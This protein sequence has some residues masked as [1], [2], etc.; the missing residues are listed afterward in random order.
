MNYL[1]KKFSN[2]ITGFKSWCRTFK[3]L[4]ESDIVKRG[5]YKKDNYYLELNKV[6]NM[7]NTGYYLG[8]SLRK[9]KDEDKDFEYVA[10][11][12]IKQLFDERIHDFCSNNGLILDY[13]REMEKEEV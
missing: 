11:K 10:D 5:Y 8:I 9:Y 2:D 1:N 7:D 13:Y 3:H 4:F 12:E 6:R